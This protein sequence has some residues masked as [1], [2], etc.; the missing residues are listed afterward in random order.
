MDVACLLAKLQGIKDKDSILVCTP[1][2]STYYITSANLCT[3]C[4][5]LHISWHPYGAYTIRNLAVK[6]INFGVEQYPVFLYVFG[7]FYNITKIDSIYKIVMLK[8]TL[9]T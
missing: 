3:N 9:H 5:L 7:N 6:L 8:T 2:N 4:V 1:E